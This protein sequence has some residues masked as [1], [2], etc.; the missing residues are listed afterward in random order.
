MENQKSRVVLCIKP[1]KTELLFQNNNGDN[2]PF[3]MNPYELKALENLAALKKSGEG[4]LPDL[5]MY[6]RQE[7]RKRFKAGT[8]YGSG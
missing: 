7:S 3:Q 5:C 2:E 6:G 1:V 8:C 4:F